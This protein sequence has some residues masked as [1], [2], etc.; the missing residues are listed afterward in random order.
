MFVLL[1]L[2]AMQQVWAD[3]PFKFPGRI[4]FK[5]IKDGNFLGDCQLFYKEKTNKKNISS[6]KLTNFQGLG[7]SSQETFVTYMFTDN[8]SIYADFLSDGKKMIHELRLKDGVTFDLKKGQV[9]IYKE[10][11]GQKN[12]EIQTE[13]FTQYPVI[14]LLSTFFMT[15]KRVALNEHMKTVKFN[16]IFGQSTKIAEMNYLGTGKEPFQGKEIS[17]EVMSLN[18]SSVEMFRLKIFKDKDGYCFPV[19]ITISEVGGTFEMRAD[20]ISKI[21][22]QEVTQ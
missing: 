6:L 12:P 20:R 14:N 19:N 16:L 18:I 13:L 1:V 15:A 5:L 8:S 2:G 21:N 4:Q 10:F 11:N 7:S 3:A 22:P 9:F 17:T